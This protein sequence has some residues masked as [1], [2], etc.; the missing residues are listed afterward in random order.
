MPGLIWWKS[1]LLI[2]A[3]Q[4]VSQVEL[5]PDQIADE[6]SGMIS[7]HK[8]MQRSG[9]QPVL[10]DIPTAEGLAHRRTESRLHRSYNP[11]TRTGS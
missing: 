1:P 5:I 2:V 10:V 8:L 9:E 6:M 4:N 11:N 7:T 3:R